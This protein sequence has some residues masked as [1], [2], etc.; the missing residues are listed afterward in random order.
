MIGR[1]LIHAILGRKRRLSRGSGT[2]NDACSEF[3][4]NNWDISQ[5]VIDTLVPVVGVLPFPLNEQMLMVAAVARLRPTHIFEWGTNIGASARIFYEACRALG[6]DTE[7][8]STDLPDDADHAEHPREK[9]GRL[10]RTI[11]QVRLH[12]GDGLDTSLAILSHG[13]DRAPKPLFFVDGDHA[14]DS[15]RRELAGIGD[16]APEA[17]I[18]LHDTFYQSGGAGYNVGPHR[19]VSEFVGARGGYR[20]ISQNLGL[21]G[22]TLLWREFPA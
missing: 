3:E 22:M 1:S 15:V 21:P 6:M 4:V 14:Y 18:L 16:A 2:L 17:A 7:I 10:V 13:R 20:V 5:F 12:L 19:A 8:H 9:R 11:P